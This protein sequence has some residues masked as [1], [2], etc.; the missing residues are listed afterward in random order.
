VKKDDVRARIEEV[1]I[2]PAVRVSSADEARF[3]AEAV[4]RGGIPIAEITMTVP[5]A[6]EAIAGLT[7]S[8]PRMI[9]GAGTV[10]DTEFPCVP[11]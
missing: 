5:N 8:I 9:V 11:D 3:A 7:R 4:N 10:L 2:I 6:T 1:G